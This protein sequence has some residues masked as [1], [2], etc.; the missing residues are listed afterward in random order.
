MNLF[1]E[2]VDVW[3]F[4]DGRPFSAGLYHRAESLFPPF[5]TV[6]QGAVRS[7]H[8]A[9]LGVDVTDPEAVRREVGTS[10][11][12]PTGFRVRG[13]FVG[14][15]TD[16]EVELFFPQPADSVAEPRPASK[17]N[18]SGEP[19]RI[20][21]RALAPREPR[22][23][24]WS[25][26]PSH[27]PMWLV[28]D[29]EPAKQEQELWLSWK[30]LA[31]YLQQ[32]TAEAVQARCLFV[33]ESRVGIALSLR[34]RTVE[35]GRLYEAEFV[36]PAEGV[37]L[38]VE[39]DGFEGWPQRGVMAVG[40][41]S[42]AAAFQ[43]VHKIPWELAPNPLP[44]RFKVYFATPTYFERGWL[45]RSWDAFFEGE[46]KLVAAALA[47]FVVGGGFEL[48]APSSMSGSGAG[49]RAGRERAARRYVPAGSVYFFEAEPGARLRPDLVNGAVTDDGAEIGFG[50]I[51][52]GRW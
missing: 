27:V 8:L 28:P 26:I 40:G 38:Y 7:K 33:R 1:I 22:A 20:V 2:P 29:G 48:A 30:E 44:G 41:E 39:V 21:L 37:G 34:T 50:Q 23:G 19:P 24:E 51:L 16:H 36:R 11:E 45:P 17:P 46:V 49:V 32:G 31:R 3:L 35:E 42:R 4:R 52:I 10:R 18:D 43:M 6:V 12:F 9:V 15:K 14:R 25:S 13:P 5:P 47:R